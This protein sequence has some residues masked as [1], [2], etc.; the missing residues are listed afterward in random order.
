MAGALSSQRSIWDEACD[1][2]NNDTS[3]N[4]LAETKDARF[5]E[6]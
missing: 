2:V 6:S 3:K 4:A 1:G 5:L